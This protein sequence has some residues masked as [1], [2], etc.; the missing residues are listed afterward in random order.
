MLE[1]HIDTC[2]REAVWRYVDEVLVPQYVKKSRDDVR[3]W[4]CDS[5]RLGS[6]GSRTDEYSS[7][8]RRTEPNVE[9]RQG[10]V[11]D[12]FDYYFPTLLAGPYPGLHD[13][14]RVFFQSEPL[15][16]FKEAKNLFSWVLNLCSEVGSSDATLANREFGRDCLMT[17]L[18]LTCPTPRI[19][20]ESRPWQWEWTVPSLL[21][22]CY[23]M[24]YL[25]LVEGMRYLQCAN[26]TCTRTFTPSRSDHK[27]CSDSC[28]RAQA[29]REY[30]RREK[31]Q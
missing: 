24:L 3:Q 29:Q 26:E 6:A 28:A 21:A 1:W 12:Y 13:P 17:H 27:Y 8:V 22:A 7:M 23:L 20:T 10:T 2:N 5:Q 14:T 25:D 16:R 15:E 31:R 19:G 11:S 9:I 4:Q 18:Q 30:R